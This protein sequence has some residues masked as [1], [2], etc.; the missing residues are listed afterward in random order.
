MCIRAVNQL[1]NNRLINWLLLRVFDNWAMHA[2]TNYTVGSHDHRILN[3]FGHKECTKV[4]E[5]AV[6]YLLVEDYTSQ[7]HTFPLLLMLNSTF[8]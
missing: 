5:E 3:S 7:S 2:T 6:N 4:S 1:C 8:G